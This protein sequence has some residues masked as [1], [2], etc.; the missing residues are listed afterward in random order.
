MV[1]EA[2]T[3]DAALE[4]ALEAATLVV[5]LEAALEAATLEAATE[6]SAIVE[7]DLT[8]SDEVLL[9]DIFADAEARLDG[10]ARETLADALLP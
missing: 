6:D 4:A 7:L 2:A 10:L 5:A 3:L 8:T 1:L 9:D